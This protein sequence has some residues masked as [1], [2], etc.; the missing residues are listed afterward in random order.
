[1]KKYSMNC[2]KPELELMGVAEQFASSWPHQ[3]CE[4]A[5]ISRSA[6]QE[7]HSKTPVA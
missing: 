6:L 7:M 3:A 2:S 1:M 5:L 4:L